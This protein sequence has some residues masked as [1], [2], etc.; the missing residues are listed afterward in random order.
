M[1]QTLTDGEL[2]DLRGTPQR[3][4]QIQILRED[5]GL[6]PLLRPDGSVVITWEVINSVMRDGTCADTLKHAGI[7]LDAIVNG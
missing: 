7:D 5:L 3:E 1:A 6:N 4:R 2:L